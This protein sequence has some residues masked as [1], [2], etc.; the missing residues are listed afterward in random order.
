M[1]AYVPVLS[2]SAALRVTGA[3]MIV[4][5]L[6]GSSLSMDPAMIQ[7]VVMATLAALGRGAGQ[8]AAA[9]PKMNPL[10]DQQEQVRDGV[11]YVKQSLHVVLISGN[12]TCLPV[13]QPI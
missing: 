1:S 12:L 7:A 11:N 2:N 13:G 8:G 6:L 9:I 3:A 5:L 10:Q 4:T